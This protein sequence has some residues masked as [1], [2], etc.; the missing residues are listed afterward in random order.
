MGA[1]H[2]AITSMD[3][4]GVTSLEDFTAV[5]AAIGRMIVS[6][7]TSKVMDVYNAF[8]GIVKPEVPSNDVWCQFRGCPEGVQCFARVQ[9]CRQGGAGGLQGCYCRLVVRRRRALSAPGFSRVFKPRKAGGAVCS[10]RAPPQPEWIN[11]VPGA[12]EV[13]GPPAREWIL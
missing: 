2:K 12:Q 3:A 4:S 11:S 10:V 7:P 8:A 1:H 5:N 13:R 6:T 9:G